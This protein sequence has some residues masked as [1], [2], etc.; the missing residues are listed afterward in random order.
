[1]PPATTT[2]E[3]L[4]VEDYRATPEGTRYQLIEGELYAMSPSPKFIH[5]AIAWNLVGIFNR[6]LERHAVGR[7][8]FAPF[9]VYLSDN[10][11]VQPDVFFVAN[12]ALRLVQDD[13]VHG[14]PD[15]VIE[16]LSPSTAQLDKKTKRR[17]YVRAGVKEMWLVD[18]SLLQIQR[19]DFARDPA[20]PVQLIEED[21]SFATPLLPGLTLSAA[22]IFKR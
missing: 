21:E 10:D 7:A 14:A 13:G 5:Q 16:I 20:K 12:D 4:T 15:L 3:L 18:P 2:P 6:Y 8:F 1:M 9:D 19:Y 11:V 17:V 22:E